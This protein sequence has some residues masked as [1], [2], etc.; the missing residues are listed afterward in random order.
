[1]KKADELFTL[2][3]TET[4]KTCTVGEKERGSR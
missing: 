2:E 1:M 3:V 4:D